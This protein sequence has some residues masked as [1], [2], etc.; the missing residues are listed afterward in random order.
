MNKQIQKTINNFFKE[1]K[2]KKIKEV[3]NRCAKK[4]KVCPYTT[5]GKCR[6]WCLV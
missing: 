4:K 3:N 5:S 1:N 6:G 2:G